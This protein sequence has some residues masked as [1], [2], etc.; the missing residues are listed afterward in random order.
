MTK[1]K[2]ICRFLGDFNDNALKSLRNSDLDPFMG[3]AL[4][5]N[6]FGWG[7]ACS[8]SRAVR[9]E[10]FVNTDQASDVTAPVLIPGV[11]LADH[12]YHPS[13]A[14]FDDG[15][16]ILLLAQTDLAEDTAIS[17]NYGA[18]SNDDIFTNY[19]FTVENNPY[20]TMEIFCDETL[21]NTARA[22]MGQSNFSVVAPT[23]VRVHGSNLG[24]SSKGMAVGRENDGKGG[25]LSARYIGI[26]HLHDTYSDKSLSKWQTF[27]LRALSLY[28]PVPSP[29]N[30]VKMILGAEVGIKS[31]YGSSQSGGLDPRLWA[32]LRVL[33]SKSESDLLKHGYN[34]SL[35]Q[36]PGSS[37]GL[38]EEAHVLRTMIGIIAVILRSYGSDIE[39]DINFLKHSLVDGGSSTQQQ[40]LLG[41]L[42]TDLISKDCHQILRR[43][44]SNGVEYWEDKIALEAGVR[45]SCQ[46]L[47]G[48]ILPTGDNFLASLD[49]L[50]LDS[51]GLDLSFNVREIYKY[52]IRR[53]KMLIELIAK[54]QYQYQV[55]RMTVIR[56]FRWLLI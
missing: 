29:T 22:V 15:K 54:L 46:L 31:K 24:A 41:T 27:W 53:K 26:G 11:D 6:S 47:Q 20:D 39:E 56:C 50:D 3:H 23:D 51:M 55:G 10:S 48:E 44:F 25:R 34:P 30:D 8:S 33:Y 1:T 19:G 43:I 16:D 13:S 32:Y 42:D 7:F 12:S 9:V 36:L 38:H 49:N 40:K 52:R 5:I 21:I 2:D 28:G 35:L 18:M 45:K 37:L 14:L 4:D 17:V